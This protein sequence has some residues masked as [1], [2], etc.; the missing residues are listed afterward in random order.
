M[1]YAWRLN[2]PGAIN[3]SEEEIHTL[4][5]LGLPEGKRLL[6]HVGT[7]DIIYELGLTEFRLFIWSVG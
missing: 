3:P 4:E 6:S 5:P 7:V 1:W 2:L